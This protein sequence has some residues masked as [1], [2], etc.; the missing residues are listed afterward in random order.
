VIHPSHGDVI[1]I[2]K[3][4]DFKR[5]IL[6]YVQMQIE[7]HQKVGP[8][9]CDALPLFFDVRSFCPVAAASFCAFLVSI[10]SW[11]R[12]TLFLGGA[13]VVEFDSGASV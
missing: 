13:G 7:Y 5:I 2:E 3:L 6:D 8:S 11:Q 4:E 10:Y 12:T 1:Q 9:H